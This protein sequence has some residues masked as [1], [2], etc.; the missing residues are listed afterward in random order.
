MWDN[1]YKNEEDVLGGSSPSSYYLS[2]FDKSRTIKVKNVFETSFL[3]TVKHIDLETGLR[4]A[5]VLSKV[6]DTAIL[7]LSSLGGDLHE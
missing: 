3:V 6:V 1:G 4:V 7:K 2:R 5:D